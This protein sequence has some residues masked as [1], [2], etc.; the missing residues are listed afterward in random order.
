MLLWAFC[1][2]ILTFWNYFR[3]TFALLFHYQRH[4][5]TFAFQ[6]VT[7]QQSQYFD[8]VDRNNR[9]NRNPWTDKILVSSIK[10]F[11]I[12]AYFPK[13]ETWGVQ[14]DLVHLVIVLQVHLVKADTWVIGFPDKRSKPIDPLTSVYAQFA[15]QFRFWAANK[16]DH[17]IHFHGLQVEMTRRSRRSILQ[18]LTVL[19]VSV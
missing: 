11:G 10:T 14:S 17:S 12:V 1:T 15:K 13:T 7:G 8:K 19:L 9:L 4:I 16:L 5:N 2:D 3:Q 6:L 18:I